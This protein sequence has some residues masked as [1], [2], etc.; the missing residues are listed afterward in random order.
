MRFKVLLPSDIMLETEARKVVAEGPHGAFGILPRHVD[1]VS[2]LLPGIVSVTPMS[3][4]EF[5]LAV[6]EGVMAKQ[7]D[8]LFLATLNAVRSENLGELRRT[9]EKHF[10]SRREGEKKSR[11]ALAMLEGSIVRNFR[12]R[13]RNW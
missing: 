5:F 12:E 10:L 6:D 13:Q 2:P 11:S 9:L 1:F 4:G 3:G 7:D 8:R